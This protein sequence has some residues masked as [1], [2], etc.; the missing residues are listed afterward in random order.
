M[1]AKNYAHSPLRNTFYENLIKIIRFAYVQP[2]QIPVVEGQKVIVA[3]TGDKVRRHAFG[4]VF[5]GFSVFFH[6]LRVG[7][8]VGEI[9]PAE[10]RAAFFQIVQREFVHFRHRLFHLCRLRRRYA[11]A[12]RLIN[13]G[14]VFAHTLY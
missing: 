5:V 1:R 14:V 12:L 8:Y 13:I 11:R 7:V 6:E 3:H 4:R 2:A 9:Y 10:Q